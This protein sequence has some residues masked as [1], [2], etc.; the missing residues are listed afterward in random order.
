MRITAQQLT[1]Q[2]DYRQQQQQVRQQTILDNQ[3]LPVSELRAS[4]QQSNYRVAGLES[5]AHQLATSPTDPGDDTESPAALLD[6]SE[7]VLSRRALLRQARAQQTGT[8]SSTTLQ[9]ATS[10]AANSQTANLQT[11]SAQT[12]Q[13]SGSTPEQAQLSLIQQASHWLSQLGGTPTT[14]HAPDKTPAGHDKTGSTQQSG[15][16]ETESDLSL[17]SQ[18][19]LM[20]S[21]L[22]KIFGITV[23]LAK[24]ADG[25]G[26]GGQSGSPASGGTGATGTAAPSATPDQAV[27]VSEASQQQEQL[28]FSAQGQVTTSDGRQLSIQLGFAMQFEQTQLNQRLTRTSALK[29]PLVLN[30][31]GQVAGFSRARFQF[32]LDADGQK[33]SLAALD[34]GSAFLARDLNGNGQIDDGTELF[35][36]RSG[37]GFADLATLDEDGNGVLDEADSSFATLRLYRPGEGLLTLGDKQIGAIFL[38]S[39]AT[40]FQHLGGVDHGE[41]DSV[42][43]DSNGQDSNGQDSRGQSPAVLRQTGIYLKENGEAGTLQQVDLRV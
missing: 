26:S 19:R 39:A 24:V 27:L 14:G 8:G 21:L 3:P 25:Q 33:E 40:P 13:A 6:S 29:D 16:D 38:Q 7:A 42:G 15:D 36:A 12:A 28:T 2:S 31:D 18:T 11:V 30:L 22:E 4:M 10:A 1:L 37:N 20:K 43:Q 9:P 17:D 41:Q 32:D 23:K 5:S 34:S 35:G